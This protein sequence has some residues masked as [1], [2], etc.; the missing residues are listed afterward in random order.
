MKDV[1]W[2]IYNK[3]TDPKINTEY[4]L[5]E[6][7]IMKLGNVVFKIKMIQLNNLDND[8][9]ISINNN[10][11]DENDTIMLNGNNN[12]IIIN[13]QNN[14]DNIN[15]IEVL[16]TQKIL[17]FA[18]NKEKSEGKITDKLK[19]EKIKNKI[20]RICYQEEDDSL[21]N[22]LIKPCKCSGSMKYIHLKC[23]L[24]WFRSRKLHHP[25]NS[26]EN[27]NFFNAYFIDDSMNCELCKEIFP[28]YIIHN[29]I[30]YCLIDFDFMQENQI[31]K[32]N[33]ISAQNFINTNHEFDNNNNSSKNDSNK[34]SNFI[35]LDTLYPL[36]DG[37][38][39]RCIIKFS[40]NNKIFIGRGLENQL[41][42][43]EI[44]VSRT[45]CLLTAQ[46]NNLGKKELKL[47]DGESKFG[48]LIL[49]QSNK[50]EIIRGK[51]LHVQI[52]NVHLVMEI[53]TK[54]SF[55]SCCNADVVDGKNIYERV[56]KRAIKVKYNI[57]I[58]NEKTDDDIEKEKDNN[59]NI[60]DINLKSTEN[61]NNIKTLK[62]IDIK[63]NIYEVKENEDIN[64]K[65]KKEDKKDEGK[66]EETKKEI[67]K[68]YNDND[69]E[70]RS[71]ILSNKRKNMIENIN[72]GIK[73][74]QTSPESNSKN[75]LDNKSI[76]ILKNIYKKTA[77]SK[78]DSESV[79][80]VEDESEKK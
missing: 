31:K 64:N 41:V 24:F 4:Y 34:I 5:T 22:P 1:S 18:N 11:N 20:C 51:P 33:I 76:K 56:N 42:L 27:N 8:K 45:H 3:K 63:S 25:N 43:N 72:G 26:V 74:I 12:S 48:T 47:E 78:K 38:K 66:K 15:N 60:N 14:I 35:I 23:L 49:L 39:Y 36:N 29:H 28:D 44:T 73:Y 10:I 67:I 62:N 9:N 32:N 7:D 19:Q 68:D 21:L 65:E 2:L 50:Y 17:V 75:L 46:R 70:K 54:K 37:N 40:K 77:K 13:E 79:V 71:H 58:L 30:K 69:F 57:K 6:G 80:I 55:F 53:P 61:N 52:G 59:E 16:K